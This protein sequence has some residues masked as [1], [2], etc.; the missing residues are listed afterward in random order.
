MLK[1]SENEQCVLFLIRNE[2]YYLKRLKF[3]RDGELTE[4]GCLNERS[5]TYNAQSALSWFRERFGEPDWI[6]K[7]INSL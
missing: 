6:H 4:I 5:A 7:R 1:L 2:Y 3:P